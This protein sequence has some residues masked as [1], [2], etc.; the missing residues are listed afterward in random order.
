VSLALAACGTG[1][2][3]DAREREETVGTEIA[4]DYNKAMDKARNVETLSFEQK[5]RTDAALDEAEAAD[6]RP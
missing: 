6:T 3:D 5:E 2:S 4:R 1:G